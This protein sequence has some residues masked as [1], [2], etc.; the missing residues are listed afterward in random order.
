MTEEQQNRYLLFK[1]LTEQF[2]IVGADDPEEKSEKM[3]LNNSN[4]LFGYYD[5]AW[6][7]GKLN[8]EFFVC[9]FYKIL[10]YLKKIIQLEKFSTSTF[11]NLERTS[12]NV[13]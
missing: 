4:N 13:C 9:T 2:I 8:M 6:Q 3:I 10:F 11:R 1:Y 7:L 5:L 12:R